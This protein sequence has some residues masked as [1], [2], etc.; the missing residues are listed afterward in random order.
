MY[1][2]FN[3][4]IALALANLDIEEGRTFQRSGIVSVD[5]IV[6]GNDLNSVSIFRVPLLDKCDLP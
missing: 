2:G 5:E 6:D 1:N 3:T 4:C